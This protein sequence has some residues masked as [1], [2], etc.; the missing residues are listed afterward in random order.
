MLLHGPCTMQWGWN[1]NMV[2]HARLYKYVAWISAIQKPII[3]LTIYITCNFTNKCLNRWS[4]PLS[5]GELLICCAMGNHT[6]SCCVVYGFQSLIL[7]WTCSQLHANAANTGQKS[8]FLAI[9]K[10][11]QLTGTLLPHFAQTSPGMPLA[12]F[13]L[14][15]SL[16]RGHHWDF[17]I[18]LR[19]LPGS[20]LFS[21]QFQL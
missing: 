20:L 7:Q 18:W 3:L 12:V 14:L 17:A 19:T 16:S 10:S 5:L 15:S 4:D 8:S 1:V 9:V 21:L 11:R 2:V 6:L 13:S